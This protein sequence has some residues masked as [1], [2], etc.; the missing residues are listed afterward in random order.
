M[1]FSSPTARGT[2]YLAKL[3]G[4]EQL[5]MTKSWSETEVSPGALQQRAFHFTGKEVRTQVPGGTSSGCRVCLLRMI[6]RKLWTST[7]HF[8][9]FD[10]CGQMS[11]A[12]VSIP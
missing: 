2:L 7:P 11:S 3:I 4:H 1:E 9:L 10:S 8:C 5:Q 6:T 12:A